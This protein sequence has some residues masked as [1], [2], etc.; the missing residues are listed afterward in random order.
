MTH[1]DPH[2]N[3]AR[4]FAP[5]SPSRAENVERWYRRL[6]W[7]ICI[8]LFLAAMPLVHLTATLKSDNAIDK[9]LADSDPTVQRY[10]KFCQ[11]FGTSEALLVA[12]DNCFPFDPRIEELAGRLERISYVSSCTTPERV[13]RRASSVGAPREIAQRM[14]ESLVSRQGNFCAVIVELKN[15]AS[16]D[17][18]RLLELVLTECDDVGFAPKDTHLAGSPVVNVALDVGAQD[19]LKHWMPVV[20]IVAVTL[21]YWHIRNAWVVLL[22]SVASIMSVL[23]TL[24]TMSLFGAT[25]N[26]ISTA[27][28]PMVL[29]LSLSFGIHIVHVWRTTANQS[30]ATGQAVLHTI[31]PSILAALTTAIGSVSL[32]MSDFE[33]VR[34][35]GLWGAVGV[36]SSFLI[37]YAWLPTML[38]SER[39]QASDTSV[40]WSRHLVSRLPVSWVLLLWPALLVMGGIGLTRMSSDADGLNM[41]SPGSETI[42]DYARIERRLTGMLPVEVIVRTPDDISIAE[43]ID[44]V[45]RVA[46][47]LQADKDIESLSLP[48]AVLLADVPHLA[49]AVADEAGFTA[50]NGT[51]WRLTAHIASREGNRLSSIIDRLATRSRPIATVEFT[52][53]VPLIVASQEEIFRSLRRSL[54]A[55]GAVLLVVL[56]LAFRSVFPAAIV[57]LLNVTPVVTV[58]GLLGWLGHSINIATLTTANIALGVVLDDSLHFIE[59]YRIAGHTEPGQPNRFVVQQ[60]A[61]MAF[62]PMVQTTV[63]AALSLAVLSF[64]S[65]GPIVEFG[66]LLAVLLGLGLIGDLILLPAVLS[67]RCGRW[68]DDHHG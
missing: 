11:T 44:I 48:L 46:L 9:W 17:R 5:P 58:F 66:S 47:A 54:L 32:V 20:G 57:L 59:Q 6:R 7:P 30:T 39:A 36:I 56:T 43:K 15:G 4:H 29:V 42:E 23:V 53:L 45:R 55:A 31:R 35:F 16:Y 24:G 3:A 26:L 41:L 14:T 25:M 63:I 62:R 61:Q 27:L 33:P 18:P 2:L 22:L 65:F 51:L 37:M 52:G 1:R 28:P 40:T 34:G 21:L 64:G 38:L 13:M 49:M 67:S 12:F 60:A 8:C 19:A 50:E 10:Q 68:F